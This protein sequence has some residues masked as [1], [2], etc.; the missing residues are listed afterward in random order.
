VERCVEKYASREL[1]PA[2]IDRFLTEGIDACFDRRDPRELAKQAACLPLD[3][4][5]DPRNG[6][7]VVVRYACSDVCPDYGRIVV[8]YLDIS[9]EEC[10]A[11][12]GEVRRDPAWKSYNGCA[13]T[14]R[15]R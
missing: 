6:A 9:E 2:Q 8:R 12:G 7:A 11:I 14:E 4:G 1:T 5:V 15:A 3:L 10:E 13:P